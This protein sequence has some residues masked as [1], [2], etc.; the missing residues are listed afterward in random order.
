M[1]DS[2]C[3]DY[4]DKTSEVLPAA[5]IGLDERRC[6]LRL[7]LM[8]PRPHLAPILHADEEQHHCRSHTRRASSP[9]ETPS[10]IPK[11]GTPTARSSSGRRRMGGHTM[12][13]PLDTPSTTDAH[14]V[15]V[16]SAPAD[17]WC[18]TPAC[19]AHRTTSPAARC[20]VLPHGPEERRGAGLEP[21]G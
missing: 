8:R 11:R 16:T 7:Q 21:R 20:M 9:C 3:T 17:A 14:P 12:G 18:S 2:Q 1:I 19:G 4:L 6:H 10:R 15:C 13:T 5:S